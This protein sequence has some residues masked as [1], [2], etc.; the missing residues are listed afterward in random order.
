MKAWAM[1]KNT[2]E[3]ELNSDI[4]KGLS[5]AEARQR[6]KDVGKNKITQSK[7]ITFWDILW[8][9]IREPLILLLLVIGVLYSI[10]GDIGDTIMII[11][12]ILTV[13]LVEVYT[14]YKAKKSIE[15]LK[16][17][18]LPTSWVVRDGKTIEIPTSQIVP[19]DILILKSGV[20]ISADA[21][22][23][24]SYGLKADE[25]QLTGESMGVLK[26]SNPIEEDAGLNDQINM[27]HMGSVI[28]GGK[29][30]AIVISTGMNT[31]LGKIAG[32]T[33]EAKE[34]KTP[35]QRSMKQLSKTLIWVA[36]FFSVLV[37]ILGLLRGMPFQE[38]IL[39]GLSFAFAIIPEEMPIIITMVLGLGSI[40]LSKKNVLIKRTK[41]AET[42]G[43]VTVIATDKTGTLTENK[44]SIERYFTKDDRLLFTLSSLMADV[45]Y[46]SNGGYLGDPMDKA[47]LDKAAELHIDR[48]R[49]LDDYNL[50][51]DCGFDETTKT[52]QSIFQ[53]GQKNISVI[54]GAPESIFSVSSC[55]DDMGIKLKNVM[56][57]GLRTIA[58]AYKDDSQEIYS[59]A[60]LICFD[61]P[62][63][64]GVPEAVASCQQAGVKV[65]MITGDH[66]DTAKRV[67]ENAGIKVTG[68]LTGEELNKIP[69][70]KFADAIKRCNVFVRISPEQKLNIVTALREN[71]EVIAVTGDGI[72]DAP[73]LKAADI[74]ISMG[75]AGTDVAK[76]AADMVL[77][78]DNFT[79]VVTAIEEG[80]RLF[81]N[82]SKCVKYYLAC[83]AGLILTILIPTIFNLPLPF[84]PIQIII[85]E[86]FMDLAASTSFVAERA[87]ADV[88]KRM[89]RNPKESFMNKSMITGILSG[90]AT[91]AAAVLATY[92]YGWLS[93]SDIATIQT[94]TFVIWLF[95]HV[96]LAFNMRTN[97]VPLIKTGVFSSRA[98]NIWMSGV[99][100]FLI[101]ALNVSVFSQYL[102]L[103]TI[104]IL[105]VLCLAFVAIAATSWMEIK[106][107]IKFSNK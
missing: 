44:M 60:G 29:G 83:K 75:I 106:K 58:V 89:P 107:L 26:T 39:T 62:I 80:R 3:R 42:L 46:D 20:K 90:G 19:G 57:A 2:L 25:S 79:E 98:F 99:V 11:F 67:A 34:P 51:N 31:E 86:L 84:S 97:N 23:L 87:E 68:V 104:G 36:V 6:L 21:R 93:G 4:S 78:N 65:I 24:E 81:D 103:T 12:V 32:M 52:F 22:I 59:I 17:L 96:A 16:T 54:K 74:G 1:E 45:I 73:A 50:I 18:A 15:A 49:F 30:K 14:E 69:L 28:L 41:A 56:S 76:E 35:L 53:Y 5:S 94:F 61:D 71:G 88:L 102:Q 77:T 38:M 63:R 85:L 48:N 100:V 66:A 70:E 9:E 64:Q 47:V 7:P 33:E 27:V 37:P 72:N 95:G 43:G 8:E 91:L 40:K 92:L 82:L 13:S 101:I 105:P 10:W 55:D